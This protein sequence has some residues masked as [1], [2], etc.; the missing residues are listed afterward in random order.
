MKQQARLRGGQ[1]RMA[2]QIFGERWEIH[3]RLP[4]G[5]QAHTFRVVDLKGDRKTSYVLKRLKNVA[6]LERFRTE[7]EALKSLADPNVIKLIDFD[8]DAKQPYLVSEFCAGG[9]LK[10]NIGRFSHDPIQALDL[11]I[12]ICEGV[13]AAHRKR[14]IHRDLKPTNIL[15]RTSNGPPVVADFGL[16]YLE[17]G[18]RHTLTEEAVGSRWFMA[19]ELEDG[20]ASDN[21][22]TDASDIYSLGKLLYWLISG[23]EIF[24]REKHRAPQYNLVSRFQDPA[25]EH[26]N[27]ILDRMIVDDPNQRFPLISQVTKSIHMAIRLLKHE[28]RA[29]S[30]DIPQRCT[31]CGEGTYQIIAKGIEGS[32]QRF[33]LNVLGGADWRIMACDQCGH[34]Q[35]FR[36]DQAKRKDWWGIR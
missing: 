18:E 32:V 28:Y 24:S 20:R 6:R 10:E 30:P 4:E 22:I 12:Q 14:I 7:V 26:I 1:T 19:P 2:A 29:V 8:F 36:V 5:G 25:L 21:D 11:F 35:L 17:G 13:T 33:G 16:C 34:I 9:N 3:E 27:R 15:L 31:Y 23:G